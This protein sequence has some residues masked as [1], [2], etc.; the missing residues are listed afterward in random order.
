MK[1][2]CSTIPEAHETT[3]LNWPKTA[4][5]FILNDDVD[6]AENNLAKGTSTFHNVSPACFAT[7]YDVAPG[8]L[9]MLTREPGNQ[10]GKG[11]VAFIRATLGFEQDIMRQ[12]LYPSRSRGPARVLTPCS[13]RKAK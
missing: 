3:E 2:S 8:F 9:Q 10:L 1:G 6:S 7:A 11:M 12:G 4:A 5:T 13:V